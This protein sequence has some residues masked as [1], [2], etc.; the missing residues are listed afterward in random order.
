MFVKSH[1][2]KLKDCS[3]ITSWLF[4]LQSTAVVQ[5][6]KLKKKLLFVPNIMEDTVSWFK[7]EQKQKLF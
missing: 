1:E 4:S 6:Q 5:N 7:I 3:S 2:L